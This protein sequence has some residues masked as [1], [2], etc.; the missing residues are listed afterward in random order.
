MAKVKPEAL[1][2]VKTAMPS[3]LAS[4]IP[5]R[6]KS[7]LRSICAVAIL[8]WMQGYYFALHI[9]LVMQGKDTAYLTALTTAQHH[10]TLATVLMSWHQSIMAMQ[11]LNG[12][13]I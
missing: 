3:N 2:P 12:W 13:S 9:F 6:V 7:P 5:L 8:N 11:V 1:R 10:R 4:C